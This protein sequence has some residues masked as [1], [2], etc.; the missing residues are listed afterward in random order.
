MR[1]TQG[2]GRIG[3][4]WL[5]GA[6]L[7]LWACS[8]NGETVEVVE[9]DGL[10]PEETVTEITHAYPELAVT[11]VSEQEANTA[12]TFDEAFVRI[13]GIEADDVRERIAGYIVQYLENPN[14]AAED[15]AARESYEALPPAERLAAL[16]E[17]IKARH[18]DFD[19]EWTG[20]GEG[21]VQVEYGDNSLLIT[22]IESDGAREEWAYAIIQIQ[23]EIDDAAGGDVGEGG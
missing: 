5:F 18:A 22:G 21:N 17:R 1:F 4:F 15:R 2:L 20:L 13:D 14:K 7:P 23:K 19:F 12:V 16:I 6:L 8:P 3:G 11:L 10:L 9:I